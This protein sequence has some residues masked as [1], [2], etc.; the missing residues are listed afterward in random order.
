MSAA[1]LLLQ[2]LDLKENIYKPVCERHSLL[3][4]F[5]LGTNKQPISLFQ[6]SKA[7]VTLLD[8]FTQVGTVIARDQ[9]QENPQI[10]M[11]TKMNKLCFH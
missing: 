10:M 6:T 8:C 9:Q 11:K 2:H 5:L 4:A 1:Q 3:I 7:S